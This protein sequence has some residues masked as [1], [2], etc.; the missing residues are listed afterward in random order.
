MSQPP[1]PDVVRDEYAALPSEAQ[2]TVAD[3]VAFLSRQSEARLKR[4]PA[5]RVPFR[6]DPIFGMWRDR[7]EMED[8][9]EYIHQLRRRE[10]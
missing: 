4:R 6:E 7:P 8:S 9:A 2:Q 5:R 10:F 3:F 1:A